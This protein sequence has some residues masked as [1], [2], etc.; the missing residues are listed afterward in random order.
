MPAGTEVTTQ[1]TTGHPGTTKNA[2]SKCS[3]N[4]MTTRQQEL[5]PFYSINAPVDGNVLI[6]V[7]Q[8]P[9]LGHEPDTHKTRKS[10]AQCTRNKLQEWKG[11]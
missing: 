1:L 7:K 2:R 3:V 4:N 11:K 10:C 6:E 8:A 5:A 9:A